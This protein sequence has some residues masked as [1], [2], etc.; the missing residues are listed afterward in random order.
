MKVANI[1]LV[2]SAVMLTGT[3]VADS[4][5]ESFR[6]KFLNDDLRW[7]QIEDRA[8]Q[9]AEVHFYY[10]GGDDN[11]NI[12]ID[13][14]VVQEMNK[15][16]VK[17][18]PHRITATKD[19]VDLALAEKNAG[20][21]LGQGSVDVVWVNGEN[22]YTLAQQNLLFGSFAERLPESIHYEWSDSDSRSQLN[23]FDF[24]FET[25]GREMPWSGEQYV[26]AANRE[27][28][29]VSDTPNTYKE[30]ESWLQENPGLFTY[31]K[32]PH[33]LG[34]T[35][36]Q[37]VLYEM[38]P[39]GTGAL[40]F[41]RNLASFTAKE[42]SEL[43]RPGFDYLNRIAPNLANV[44]QGS[45]RYPENDAALMNLFRNSEIAIECQFGLFH[46]ANL[47]RQGKMPDSAEEIILPSGN[48][49][50]N[51]NY[52]ALIGNAPNPAASLVFINYMSS[53]DAQKD[54][55]DLVGYPVGLDSWTLNKS[56]QDELDAVTPPHY[57][58][59]QADLD[60]NIAPDT[61][62]S[63]VNLIEHIWIKTVEQKGTQNI[64]SLVETYMSQ[65]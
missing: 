59:T 15:L 54:K 23:K 10:W 24:G 22:F 21:G 7:S 3:V 34:N 6:T 56:Q 13:S 62:A 46:V 12:W 20:K 52:L 37:Q 53:F 30:L 39:Y 16:G 29:P 36:V 47:K 28:L 18:I 43:V 40:P 33:Y 17:L 49:I 51:K 55:I 31:V 25:L 45:P 19:V 48:M 64:E 38:N 32:P 63:L 1:L 11:L 60:S 26:C 42:F 50:K 2:V 8:R 35:F 5:V 14:I 61:N 9:E 65:Q 27:L 4:D 58:L 41:Q 57:G 44:S